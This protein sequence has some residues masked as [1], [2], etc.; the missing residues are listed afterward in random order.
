LT[1]TQKASVQLGSPAVTGDP[2]FLKGNDMGKSAAKQQDETQTSSN[3]ATALKQYVDRFERLDE[4]RVALGLDV[5]EL[6]QQ[7][8]SEGFDVPTIKAMV[9]IRKDEAKAREKNQLLQTYCAAIQL[10][11]I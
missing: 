7:A 5:K 1:I 6:S 3:S 9:K 10:E 2:F 8:A 4:Q 11:L